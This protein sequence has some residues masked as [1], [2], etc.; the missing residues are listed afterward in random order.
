MRGYAD[1]LSASGAAG[2]QEELLDDRALGGSGG[3]YADPYAYERPLDAVNRH[4]R[5]LDAAPIL[6]GTAFGSDQRRLSRLPPGV[7][8]IDPF[9][10]NLTADPSP[11]DLAS[12]SQPPASPG[13]TSFARQSPVRSSFLGPGANGGPSV[14]SSPLGSPRLSGASGTSAASSSAFIPSAAASSPA[15]S[16]GS[17]EYG[18]VPG[19]QQPWMKPRASSAGEGSSG[20]F[21]RAQV[22]NGLLAAPPLGGMPRGVSQRS[23]LSGEIDA[24]AMSIA[25]VSSR[26]PAAAIPGVPTDS[27]YLNSKLYQRTLKAQKA[28]EKERAKAAS[29]GKLSRYDEEASK[30]TSSLTLGFGLG[31]RRRSSVDSSRPPSIM[32]AVGV[33]GATGKRSGRKSGLGWF[34]S[35]SEAALTLSSSQSPPLEQLAPP[36]PTSKSSSQLSALGA[37]RRSPSSNG[38]GSGVGSVGTPGGGAGEAGSGAV[39]PLPPSP[40]LPSEATLRA[41]GVSTEQLRAAAHAQQPPYPPSPQPMSGSGSSSPRSASFGP[42]APTAMAGGTGAAPPGRPR[43]AGRQGSGGK[44]SP[45]ASMQ[46]SMS[47]V[48]PSPSESTFTGSQGDHFPLPTQPKP[49]AVPLAPA[50]PPSVSS[51]AAPPAPRTVPARTAS[52]EPPSQPVQLAAVPPRTASRAPESVP[53]PPSASHTPTTPTFSPS[54]T[55]SPP[56]PVPAAPA[57]QQS[58]PLSPTAAAPLPSSAPVQP[59]SGPPQAQPAPRPAAPSA[60]PAGAA[61]PS[62]LAPPQPVDPLVK[63]RKSGLGLLFSN[64]GSNSNSPSQSER[65]SIASSAGSSAATTRAASPAAVEPQKKLSRKETN[66][67]GGGFFGFGGS[68]GGNKLLRSSAGAGGHSPAPSAA[69]APPPPPGARAP[70]MPGK[71][72]KEKKKEKKDEPFFHPSQALYSPPPPPPQAPAQ[73]PRSPPMQQLAP[74]SPAPPQGQPYSPQIRAINASPMLPQQQQQQPPSPNPAAFAPHPHG[75]ANGHPAS[76]AQHAARTDSSSGSSTTFSSLSS[77]SSTLPPST[78]ANVPF[79]I[80]PDP[81]SGSTSKKSGFAAF[82]GGGGG[83]MRARTK[84]IPGQQ[85]APEKALPGVPPVAQPQG[86]L[87][88]KPPRGQSLGAGQ[89]PAHPTYA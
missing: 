42:T 88:R 33:A 18:F 20:G 1:D 79:S 40:N 48:P 51:P 62:S 37:G 77:S 23:K 3:G 4:S 36:M 17:S 80:S 85:G 83:S 87:L 14:S 59:R 89:Q 65:N 68:G 11:Y 76:S 9:G 47:P 52:L 15:T 43:S 38:S 30:S 70:V 73:Q 74:R 86:A 41:M 60:L 10:F 71:K 82:F 78:P 66:G 2:A 56:P 67:G 13:S 35:S 27:D 32:S 7:S 29:K 69:S 63:R 72:E 61:P 22:R 34:R 53:L 58:L 50:L 49:T 26:Q 64:R 84:S 28:L 44:R 21:N 46:P 6:P 31:H 45:Q 12:L 57:R 5:L 39:T 54:A 75:L 19:P 16:P 81:A 25:S 8:M 55:A 24:D